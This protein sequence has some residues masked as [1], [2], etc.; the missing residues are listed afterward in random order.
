MDVCLFC[1]ASF[2]CQYAGRRGA[3]S[4]VCFRVLSLHHFDVY[5]LL[6]VSR[7]GFQLYLQIVI[8]NLEPFDFNKMLQLFD[9]CIV[10]RVFLTYEFVTLIFELSRLDLQIL[11]VLV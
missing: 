2:L 4:C 6:F 9:L 5:H 8:V 11:A 10:C 1:C 3:I 7:V